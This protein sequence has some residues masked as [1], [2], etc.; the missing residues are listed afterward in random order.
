MAENTGLYLTAIVGVV[1]VVAVVI[2]TMN[3]GNGG[4]AVNSDG[5][6]ISGQAFKM[7]GGQGKTIVFANTL[8]L[9]SARPLSESVPCCKS[10]DQGCICSSDD[11]D[12]CKGVGR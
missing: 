10:D 12:D 11:C 5:T 3:T 8:K 1:A 7:H 6:D 4:L 9:N 2:L